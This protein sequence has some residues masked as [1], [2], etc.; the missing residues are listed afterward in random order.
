MVIWSA[1][2]GV[3]V[4]SYMLRFVLFCNRNT[5]IFVMTMFHEPDILA[6]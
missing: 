5:V 2:Y 6:K 4:T 3:R 1:E